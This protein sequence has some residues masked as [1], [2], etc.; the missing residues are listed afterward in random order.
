MTYTIEAEIKPEWQQYYTTHGAVLLK[1]LSEERTELIASLTFEI[2][3]FGLKRLIERALRDEV[4]TILKT[5]G[6]RVAERFA[7]QPSEAQ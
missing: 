6:D 7:P 3:V 4:A 1:S 2:N 5:Q